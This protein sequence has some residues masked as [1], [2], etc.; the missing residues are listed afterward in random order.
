MGL[1]DGYGKSSQEDMSPTEGPENLAIRDQAITK[2]TTMKKILYYTPFWHKHDF[3]F[4]T[5]SRPFQDFQCP[6]SSCTTESIHFLNQSKANLSDYDAV[7]FSVQAHDNFDLQEHKSRI[8]SWRS[9]HQRF[10]FFMMESQAYPIRNISAMQNFFNWT[11]TFRWDSDIP[12]PYGWFDKVGENDAISSSYPRKID[13]WKL[14][15]AEEFRKS[16]PQRSRSF[17]DFAKRQGKVAWI[18]SNCDTDS[19]REDF[20][21][22]LKK[23][24]AVDI[25]GGKCQHG[26]SPACDRPYSV[27]AKDNCTSHVE[28][29]YKFYLAFENQFCNDYVTEKFFQR[30]EHSVV[31]TLGQ[32]N[33]S[34]IAPPHSSISV[35]DFESAKDLARYLIELDQDDERYLSYFWWKDH[36]RVRHPR[37]NHHLGHKNGFGAS[38]C[39]LCA[40]LHDPKEPTKVYPDMEGWWR[41]PAECGKKLHGLQLRMRQDQTYKNAARSIGGARG[42][43]T[44]LRKKGHL[45]NGGGP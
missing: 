41:N 5:G 4:G 28:T 12:R 25:F 33:Y 15:D 8:N 44:F 1:T 43:D 19:R 2:A 45:N 27:T 16:L 35:F 42:I 24:I 36:Y 9:P 14:Y 17:L 31:I 32:G 3:Q 38:M 40:K 7:L 6:I 11:M 21:Y 22:Q 29:H 30:M 37:S 13:D 34:D 39:H 20:V 26:D 10:I 23:Y 18:V